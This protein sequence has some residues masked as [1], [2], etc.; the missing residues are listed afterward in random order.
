M[1][2][3]KKRPSGQRA[4]IDWSR[5]TQEDVER[6]GRIAIAKRLGVTPG[7]VTYGVN[8]SRSRNG[9][10]VNKGGRKKLPIPESLTLDIP[11]ETVQRVYQVSAPTAQ[12]WRRELKARAAGE[13]RIDGMLTLAIIAAIVLGLGQVL[14]RI[15][16]GPAMKPEPKKSPSYEIVPR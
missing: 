9:E 15:A 7:A 10:P 11:Q 4:N 13:F 1:S 5:I 2:K 16:S 12:R 6:E 8:Q 3:K 14:F